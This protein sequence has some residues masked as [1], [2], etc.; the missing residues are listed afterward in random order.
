MSRSRWAWIVPLPVASVARSTVPMIMSG[1][2]LPASALPPVFGE[3]GQLWAL[4]TKICMLAQALP[5]PSPVAVQVM[6][7]DELLLHDAWLN[8]NEVALPLPKA[9]ETDWA[10]AGLATT[11]RTSPARR[12]VRIRPRDSKRGASCRAPDLPEDATL[13]GSSRHPRRPASV[14]LSQGPGSPARP[15]RDTGGPLPPALSMAATSSSTSALPAKARM[16]PTW[17]ASSAVTSI[18]MG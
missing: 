16:R 11:S 5:E 15:P 1:V 7:Y 6:M 12:G 9:R 8:G 4:V 3:F 14:N 17:I 2:P 18:G 13:G 10:R